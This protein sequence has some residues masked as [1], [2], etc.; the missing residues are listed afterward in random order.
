MKC[1]MFYLEMRSD[2]LEGHVPS[3]FLFHAELLHVQLGFE[4]VIKLHSFVGCSAL[5]IYRALFADVEVNGV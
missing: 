1:D 3:P 2:P 5:L 4:K